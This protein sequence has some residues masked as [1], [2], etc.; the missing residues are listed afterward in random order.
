MS[1][2]PRCLALFGALCLALP[3]LAQPL[4]YVTDPGSQRVTVVNSGNNTILRKLPGLNES[5]AV[6]ITPDGQ[7][8]Y[9]A[10]TATSSKG[11]VAVID[12]TKVANKNVNPVIQTLEVGGEPIALTVDAQ[13]DLLYVAD[14]GAN[15]VDAYKLDKIDPEDPQP[16]DQYTLSG[17]LD[18]M[19]LSPDGKT[20]ALASASEKAITLYNLRKR[21]A[22]AKAT[23]TVPLDAAPRALGFSKNGEALWIATD[24][25]FAVYSFASA[26]VEATK[27]QGGT[28][29]V[30]AAPRTRKVYFGANN[31]KTV[32][33]H[34][35]GND[36]LSNIAVDGV[37]SGLALSAD[38]TRLYVVQS[39]QDCG[40]DVVSTDDDKAFHQ[41][42]FGSHS[43]TTGD[44]AGPGDIH[45]PNA[46][47]HG[48][49]GEQLSGSVHADDYDNR[50]L[51]YDLL[52]KPDKGTLSFN[53]TGDYAYTPPSNGYSGIQHF[54]W[55]A[56]ASNGGTG[57]PTQPVS[58]PITQ[59][60][61]IAPTISSIADQKADPDTTLGPLNF[62]LT[63]SKDLEL[64]KKSSNSDLVAADKITISAGCGSTSLS[65]SVKVPVKNVD[66]GHTVITLT[67]VGP[68]GL[69]AATSFKVKVGSGDNG[70]G[71]G[72]A[73]L[74]LAAL[75][76]FTL[77][78]MLRR[79]Q[80]GSRHE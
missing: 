66:N 45:A 9:V 71:G 36:T 59:T 2:I 20:L 67:A 31:G 38:G 50:P 40:I 26:S 80:R 14:A 41:T 4:V 13:T 69:S 46:A 15:E 62:T 61:E 3:A 56:K 25:G 27:L 21:A 32:Y 42:K 64:V 70:G 57:S 60:L 73:P 58:R 22:Q 75:G 72:L 44:F 54:L 74:L 29:S 12:G 53:D 63:G 19:A 34:N 10:F 47:T 6:T 16:A 7:R 1:F 68:D 49:A 33:V 17:S 79:K 65:C 11:A 24:D 28:T 8:V 43:A 77:L 76:L 37:V 23:T 30:A 5:R 48:S 39:C 51:T 52:V 55:Q 18:A 78:I 35:I